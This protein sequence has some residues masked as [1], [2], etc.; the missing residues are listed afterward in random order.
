MYRGSAY[1][2]LGR[3]SDANDHMSIENLAVDENMCPPFCQWFGG[4]YPFL[5]SAL[6]QKAAERGEEMKKKKHVGVCMGLIGS[7]WSESNL[8]ITCQLSRL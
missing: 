1:I 2:L 8:A 3:W 5:S 7:S 4:V 6:Q